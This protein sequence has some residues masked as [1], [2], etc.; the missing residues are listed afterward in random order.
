[1]SMNDGELVAPSEVRCGDQIA[2]LTGRWLAV[3]R[4]ENLGV[5]DALPD[6]GPVYGIYGAAAD[7]R[8]MVSEAQRVR[9][10]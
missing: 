6:D 8:L 9:R 7:E 4:V 5:L 1:M 2:D 10:R 3:T